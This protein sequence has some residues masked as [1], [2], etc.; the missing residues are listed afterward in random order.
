[1]S[2]HAAKYLAQRNFDAEH[3]QDK[4][5]VLRFNNQVIMTC[6]PN[7]RS[8][9]GPSTTLPTTAK[10]YYMQ[11]DEFEWDEAK[12]ARNLASHGV[13]FEAARLAFDDAFAVSREDRRQDY[14]EDRFIL[15]GMVQEHLLVVSYTMRSERVRIISARLAEPRERR[16]YHEENS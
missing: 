7:T 16:R 8:R 13:S 5:R 4:Q 11:D 14:G 12:A 1:L 2:P 9:N 15:L 3:R 6:L 10:P